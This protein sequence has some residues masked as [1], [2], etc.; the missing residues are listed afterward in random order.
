MAVLF[1]GTISAGASQAVTVVA[2][3]IVGIETS[4]PVH[5]K[6]ANGALIT[7]SFAKDAINVI[8]TATSISISPKGI[9]STVTVHG[10]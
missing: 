3:T 5:I 4:E 8:P 2:N 9:A 7:E 1:S 6:A 10:Q